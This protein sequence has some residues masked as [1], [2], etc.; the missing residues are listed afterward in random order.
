MKNHLLGIVLLVACCITSVSSQA[1]KK[2]AIYGILLDNTGSMR[3]QLSREI[4]VAK[5]IVKN[6]SDRASISIFQFQS[7]VNNHTSVFTNG[8]EASDDPKVLEK[9][10]DQIVT[11]SG[12]TTLLDAI[13]LSAERLGNSVNSEKVLIIISDGEDRVSSTKVED[14]ISELKRI[15][16]KVYAVGLIDEL[17]NDS[18]WPFDK[19]AKIYDASTGKEVDK[20]IFTNDK[21]SKK[22]AKD[23][24]EKI[25]KETGGK[26]IFPKKKQTAA[27]LGK[28]LFESSVVKQK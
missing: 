10:L 26:V 7:N 17:S 3:Q 9:H 24:L 23:F 22:K 2:A 14:L 1:L 20:S 5:E 6:V 11:V 28:L 25:A 19:S 16:I 12:Q 4:D 13:K 21:N 8:I 27:E 18:S 15:G